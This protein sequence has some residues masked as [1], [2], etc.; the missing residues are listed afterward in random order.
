MEPRILIYDVETAPIIATVWQK[1]EANMI[2]SVQD[3]YML[4]FAYKWLGG[5][6]SV[7]AQP[8]FKS[9]KA[10]S[11]D[12][13]AV[14]KALWGLFDEADVVVAHNG[15][16]FD[17]KKSNAR[18]IINGLKP[19]SPYQQVDTKL[20]AKRYFNFTSNK[21]DDLGE[22][23]GLGRKLQTDKDLWR[24]CMAG[25]KRSWDYMKKYNKQDVD[26]LEQVY[27][28]MKPWDVQH[29]NMAN[30]AGRPEVCP[31]CLSNK[32]M[33]AQGFRITKTARYRRWQC[34]SCGSYVSERKQMKGE[35]PIYV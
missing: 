15:N 22:Y 31:K 32:G 35:S 14:L 13:K 2:W 21:L 5:R 20:V 3:W 17:Q 6:T 10:G 25:N 28:K 18:F 1:W 23:L 7:V 8:D 34:K 4:C 33:L 9:Y 11:S 27:L 19:P 24:G 12:D 26:L 16:S 30:I 29:P